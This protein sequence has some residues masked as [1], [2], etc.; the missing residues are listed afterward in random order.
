MSTFIFFLAVAAALNSAPIFR[1]K[2][3]WEGEREIARVFVCEREGEARE[4]VCVCVACGSHR[5]IPTECTQIAAE[6]A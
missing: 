2:R 1:L 5:Y 4:G 6:V 3:T